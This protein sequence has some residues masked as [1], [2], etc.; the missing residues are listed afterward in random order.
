M[1]S[2]FPSSKALLLSLHGIHVPFFRGSVVLFL[3]G[4]PV[5]FF[6]GFAVLFLHGI[7]VP[8]FQGFAVLFLHGIPVSFFHGFAVLFLHGI[9]VPFFH[10]FAVLL[11]LCI[12]IMYPSEYIY[13]YTIFYLSEHASNDTNE[14]YCFY[15]NYILLF[16]FLG[17]ITK[18]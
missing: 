6:H 16:A 4:I 15:M 14:V 10:G 13:V 7:P 18:L 8:F 9:P 2:L 11:L 5:P 12:I 17:K 1:G 3:H